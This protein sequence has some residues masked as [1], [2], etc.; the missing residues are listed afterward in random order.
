[1]YQRGCY[2]QRDL[3][4][5]INWYKKAADCGHIRSL[6]SISWLYSYGPAS[7]RNRALGSHFCKMAADCGHPQALNNWA[8]LLEAG[9]EGFIEKDINKA[10][11]YYKK[12]IDGGN[13]LAGRILICSEIF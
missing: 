8:S 11:E 2:V 7:F 4:E 5:A 10:M 13:F 9:C 1:M 12:S 6:Y 3:N